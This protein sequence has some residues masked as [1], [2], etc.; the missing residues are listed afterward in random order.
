MELR[1]IRAFVAVAEER[2]FGRAAERLRMA[3]PAL[4]LQ[5]RSLERSLGVDLVDRGS[6]PVLLTPA[7]ERFL[8]QARVILELADRARERARGVDQGKRAILKFGSSAIGIGPVAEVILREARSRLPDVELQ[9]HVGTIP[10][11]ILAL[12][13]RALDV[14]YAYLPFDSPEEPH[15][16]RLGLTEHVLAIPE[17]HRFASM[18]Q[19]PREELLNEPFIMA[20]KDL[21]RPAIDHVLRLLFGTSDPPNPVEISTVTDRF[22]LVAEGVGISVV[23]VPMESLLP[24]RGV[25]YRRLADP[26]P[27]IEYGLL[28]FDDHASP[29]LP[30]LLELARETAMRYPVPASGRIA[31]PG[32][33]SA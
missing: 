5:V 15:Y 8:E 13:R 9:V 23:G 2:H 4:S 27:T 32:L 19:V 31:V 1:Q 21:N 20:P 7:G 18:E 16:L 11:N 25:V 22:R 10:Q 33:V 24:L 12:N 30:A 29:A 14:V 28:W 17:G 26:S 3:Q 6:R